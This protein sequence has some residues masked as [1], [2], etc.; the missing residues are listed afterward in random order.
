MLV[1]EE[2]PVTPRSWFSYGLRL[3]KDERREAAE[4][5]DRLQLELEASLVKAAKAKGQKV[6][7]LSDALNYLTLGECEHIGRPFHE[8][9]NKRLA[10]SKALIK[11]THL[12]L[13][14]IATLCSIKHAKQGRL[15]KEFEARFWNR[16][17]IELDV[18]PA[19]LANAQAQLLAAH[20]ERC[21]VTARVTPIGGYGW[22]KKRD[23]KEFSVE[24]FHVTVHLADKLSVRILEHLPSLT[25]EQYESKCR[26]LDVP[27]DFIERQKR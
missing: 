20:A 12:G 14:Q 17:A 19:H 5:R 7:K 22:S 13:A 3:V 11:Q 4:E 9:A 8:Q 23:L 25:R 27:V 2:L 26:E 15:W 16:L 24:R 18:H 10:E 1:L 21:G 6:H